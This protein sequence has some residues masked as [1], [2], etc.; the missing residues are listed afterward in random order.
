MNTVE[1]KKAQEESSQ[2]LMDLCLAHE[3]KT[4]LIY[5]EKIVIQFLEVLARQGVVTLM[6]IADRSEDIERCE[7][8]AASI[9]EVREVHN[10]IYYSPIT[11]TYGI[12][13]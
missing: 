10:E 3:I 8:L 5:K 13:F 11:A 12:H 7:K 6:G 4:A 1:F 9:S 2:K